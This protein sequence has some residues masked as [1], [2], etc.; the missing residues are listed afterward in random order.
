M[1]IPLTAAAGWLSSTVGS[2]ESLESSGF[3]I[4]INTPI[5]DDIIAE[6]PEAQL[7]DTCRDE[8]NSCDISEAADQLP[9]VT[10]SAQP[11]EEK[12]ISTKDYGCAINSKQNYLVSSTLL[13]ESKRIES[14]SEIADASDHQIKKLQHVRY[15]VITSQTP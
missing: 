12:G 11:I 1:E 13:E 3:M 7:S 9:W 8:D 15:S 10:I 2:S 5:P 14:I 6:L 4:L